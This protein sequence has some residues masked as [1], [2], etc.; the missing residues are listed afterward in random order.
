[1]A[2][3]GRVFFGDVS[4]PRV[5]RALRAA[6]NLDPPQISRGYRYALGHGN[7]S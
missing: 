5:Q 1:M 3:A 6:E 4:S 2:A 7:R